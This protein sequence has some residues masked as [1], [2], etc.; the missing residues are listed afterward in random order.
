MNLAE[1][2]TVAD[3][4][5]AV[6][7]IASIL[8]LAVQVRQNTKSSRSAT[9]Q[10][11][12]ARLSERLLHVAT[13][14]SLAELIALDWEET[15]LSPVQRTKIIYWVSA[16]LVDLNDMYGQFQLGVIPYSI[17]HTRISVIRIRLFQTEVGKEIWNNLSQ[18]Y[19]SQFVSW[20]ESEVGITA[21]ATHKFTGNV[22]SS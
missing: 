16:I 3:V 5:A 14:E 10:A 6:G 18:S 4:V 8:Y 15:E 19:S 20:F 2:S 12:T 17:L 13:N 21:S 9:M 22:T 11:L 7:M 1:I